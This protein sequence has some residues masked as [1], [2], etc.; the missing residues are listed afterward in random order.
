VELV[1]N[2]K[3]MA[4]SFYFRKLLRA[5]KGF[6]LIA[7]MVALAAL[8]IIVAGIASYTVWNQKQTRELSE[9]GDILNI[10]KTL[11]NLDLCKSV[12][13]AID[14]L[15]SASIIPPGSYDASGSGVISPPLEFTGTK[16]IWTAFQNPSLDANMI[17]LFNYSGQ[18]V[19]FNSF[20]VRLRPEQEG[21]LF[22][23]KLEYK[24]KPPR[25]TGTLNFM[26]WG[27]SLKIVKNKRYLADLFVNGKCN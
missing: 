10:L 15:Q 11:P 12:Q 20:Y 6:S 7:L 22:Y 21:G 3:T 1:Y 9:R 26:D 19:N 18:E 24:G 13:L 23:F 25:V 14:E 27:D 8:S 2:K 5:R 4:K 16:G 17:R